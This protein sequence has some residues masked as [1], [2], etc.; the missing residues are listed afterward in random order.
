MRARLWL[1]GGP[2]ISQATVTRPPFPVRAVAHLSLSSKR[3]EGC[4]RRGHRTGG[5]L[6]GQELPGHGTESHSPHAVPARDEYTWR[7]RYPDEWQTV[8]G[9]WP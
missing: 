2:W 3:V 7:V 1:P 4:E 5:D 9:A 6:F 8:G